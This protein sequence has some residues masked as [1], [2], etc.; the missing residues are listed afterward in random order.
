M[1]TRLHG[2]YKRRFIFLILSLAACLTACSRPTGDFGRAAPS[3]VHDSL[4]PKLG[5]KFALRRKETVSQFS[6]TDEEL[7]LANLAWTIVRPLHTKDWISG[8]LIEGRRTRI[9]PDINDKLDHRAYLFW[10]QIERFRSSETR[11]N[12][13]ISDL[14]ADQ[15][16]IAP[17]YEQARV[18]Y[19]IDRQRI[20][21]LEENSDVGADF[22]TNTRARIVENENLIN[23]ALDSLKFRYAAYDH[24]IKHLALESPSPR[25]RHAEEELARYATLIER[26]GERGLP[27][28]ENP[29]LLSSRIKTESPDKGKSVH[30]PSDDDAHIL[31]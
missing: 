8:T 5:S 27:F 13:I 7:K 28:I 12:R 2:I 20:A 25:V 9:F 26:G 1:M 3:V 11:W 16:T 30:D 15:G 29:E 14:R 10:L 19:V 18:V 31:K 17:F 4:A 6:R 22:K 21:F 23:T 24:A